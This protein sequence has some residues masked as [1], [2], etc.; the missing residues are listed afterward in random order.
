MP[1][2][3]HCSHYHNGQRNREATAGT[4]RVRVSTDAQKLFLQTI[5]HPP[6]LLLFSSHSQQEMFHRNLHETASLSQLDVCDRRG[7]QH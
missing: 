6:K 5:C 2:R 3:M 1:P 7:T 4:L